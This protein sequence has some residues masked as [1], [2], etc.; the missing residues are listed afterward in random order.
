MGIALILSIVPKIPGLDRLGKLPGDIQ[1]EGKNVRFYFPWV[2][3][4][5]LSLFLTMLFQIF[6]GIKK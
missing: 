5:I 2:T 3:C 1:I 6:G 4:L